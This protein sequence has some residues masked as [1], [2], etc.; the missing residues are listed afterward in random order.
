MRRGRP[1]D[2]DWQESS[3]ELLEACR[4]EKDPHPG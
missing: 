4:R 3:D 2:I 1:L